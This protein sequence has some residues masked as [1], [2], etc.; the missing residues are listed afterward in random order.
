MYIA[1]RGVMQRCAAVQRFAEHVQQAAKTMFRNGHMQRCTGII[2]AH[3]T[4]QSGSTVQRY[5]ADIAF[6]QVLM[7]FEQ[8]GFMIH[9]GT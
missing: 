1:E 8:V 2:D 6:V 7:Y 4:L 5:G 3:A 9:G